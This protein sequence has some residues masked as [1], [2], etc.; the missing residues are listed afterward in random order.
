M[1]RGSRIESKR[2]LFEFD[3]GVLIGQL[4]AL[5]L[6]VRNATTEIAMVAAE[7]VFDEPLSAKL[8]LKAR[9]LERVARRLDD[10]GKKLARAKSPHKRK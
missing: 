1:R 3:R 2:D 9:A 8:K 5:R 4:N 10:L 6:T 7:N